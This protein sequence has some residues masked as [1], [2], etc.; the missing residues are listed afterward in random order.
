MLS[1]NHFFGKTLK[2]PGLR[3]NVRCVVAM[4]SRRSSL[5]VDT[6]RAT[7][8]S[9]GNARCQPG[10]RMLTHFDFTH[11]PSR[12]HVA[13]PTRQPNCGGAI[14]CN[15]LLKVALLE[16]TLSLPEAGTASRCINH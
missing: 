16:P 9:R 15:K 2:S 13:W 4:G 14:I 5:C 3:G 6:L 7:A 1:I 12:E 8:G 11:G 10:N